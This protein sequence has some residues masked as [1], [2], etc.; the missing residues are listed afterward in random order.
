[1]S[2]N[3]S[4]GGF[5]MA[6]RAPRGNLLIDA[7]GDNRGSAVHQ[8]FHLG[9]CGGQQELLNRHDAE[10]GVSLTH[11]NVA[12]ALITLPDQMFSDVADPLEGAGHR[13]A[14]GGMFG[15]RFEGHVG[16]ALRWLA[17]LYSVITPLPA[18]Q[19]CAGRQTDASTDQS[20]CAHHRNGVVDVLLLLS[21]YR[22][23]LRGINRLYRSKNNIVIRGT[24][25][26]VRTV[27]LRGRPP[28]RRRP[29]NHLLAAL[30]EQDFRRLLPYMTT[31]PIRLKQVLHQ[32]GE[33][34]RAVY[35]LNGGAASIVTLLADGTMVEATTV[36]NEGMLGI[37]AF[38]GVGA[39][40]RAKP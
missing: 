25:S 23:P 24:A 32:A 31:V 18:T 26:H 36:G 8:R 5:S 27:R 33:P 39:V 40:I 4:Q 7:R 9:V 2:V 1:M 30:P 15:S 38:L 37:E 29:K 20:D 11:D 12:R 13:D 21:W 35:F 19:A 10:E 14:R 22:R 17:G 3:D 6:N 34:L 16:L 28:S